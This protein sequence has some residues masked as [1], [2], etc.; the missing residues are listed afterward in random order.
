MKNLL[1]NSAALMLGLSLVT[2]LFAISNASV[3][4]DNLTDTPLYLY[5]QLANNTRFYQYPNEQSHDFKISRADADSIDFY[6]VSEAP[7]DGPNMLCYNHQNLQDYFTYTLTGDDEQV[8]VNGH[9]HYDHSYP[10]SITFE[11]R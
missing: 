9:F 4:V 1:K 8:F 7:F 11:S 10:G 6:E 3:S 5:C 2:P